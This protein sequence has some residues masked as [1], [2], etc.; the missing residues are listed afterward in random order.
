VN[1]FDELLAVQRFNI[2][3][4]LIELMKIYDLPTCESQSLRAKRALEAVD[5]ALAAKPAF[6][7]FKKLL[8]HRDALSDF[9]AVHRT[10]ELLDGKP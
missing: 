9:L 3:G 10:A 6:S 4:I 2:E 1:E 7:H 8:R 5:T